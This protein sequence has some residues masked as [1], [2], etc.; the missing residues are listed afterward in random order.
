MLDL[1]IIHEIQAI[2]FDAYGDIGPPEH[3][4][5]ELDDLIALALSRQL[6]DE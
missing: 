3:V 1:D 5:D 6:D 2:V 4:I